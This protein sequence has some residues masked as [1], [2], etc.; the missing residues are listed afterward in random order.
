MAEWGRARGRSETWPPGI[1][2]AGR[3]GGLPWWR[4]RADRAREAADEIG[5]WLVAE[6]APGRLGHWLPVAFGV[7]I[8]VYFAAEREPLWWAA[9]A[10]T[11]ALS[12]AT[13]AVRAR[14][15][16]FPVVLAFCAAAAGFTTATIRTFEIAHPVLRH[17][18]FGV[19]IAGWVEAREERARSDRITV[20][21]GSIEGRRLDEAP[22]R[23]RLSVRKKTMPPVGAYVTLKAR[24][25]PP[26]T[27]LRP[28]GY[29]FS[30][31]LF[32]QRIGASGFVLGEIRIAEPPAA[33]GF[34]LRY[35]AFIEGIRDRVDERIRAVLP[36]DAGSIASALLTGK[37]DAISTPVNDAMYVSSL[38]HVLSISG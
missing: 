37:R 5:R 8:A 11:L 22:E 3:P 1:A 23:V 9:L 26:L 6:V 16:A 7:G 28:G 19:D 33:P 12:A 13:I 36:G 14:P 24:L 4:G 15:L 34:W 18:A 25:S 2:G 10:L 27:P 38:A 17:P 29:D 20:R 31:D 32:F 35:A 30:R 21:V